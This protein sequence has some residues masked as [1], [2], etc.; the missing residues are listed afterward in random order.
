MGHLPVGMLGAGLIDG[1]SD[2]REAEYRRSTVKK[3]IAAL[4]LV[5]GEAVRDG[6]LPRNRAKDRARRTHSTALLAAREANPRGGTWRFP[7]STR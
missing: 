3:T 7:T 2:R 4:V 5:L 1:A 6:L